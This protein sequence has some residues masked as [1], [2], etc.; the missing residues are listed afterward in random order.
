MPMASRRPQTGEMARFLLHHRHEA[1]ECGAVFA[2]FKGRE[3]PLRHTTALSSCAGGGHAIWWT[4]D[5]VDES[6]AL[7]QL[8]D[9]VACRTTVT[10]VADVHIP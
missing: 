7:A 10:Q 8:P 5:D 1:D 9:Y 6:R 2:S 4:V 3:S